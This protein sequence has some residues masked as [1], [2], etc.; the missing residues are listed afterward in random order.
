MQNERQARLLAALQK[1]VVE[2]KNAPPKVRDGHRAR[3]GTACKESN[4]EKENA[5]E[6]EKHGG[7]TAALT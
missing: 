6:E 4:A 5:D 3:T 7:T 2:V 1:S